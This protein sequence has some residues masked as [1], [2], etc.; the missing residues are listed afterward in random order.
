MTKQN[1]MRGLGEIS[2]EHE[3]PLEK[4]MD[5]YQKFK[6][7]LN[8]REEKYV[9]ENILNNEMYAVDLTERYYRM[10][11]KVIKDEIICKWKEEATK[12]NYHRN[13]RGFKK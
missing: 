11:H 3:I 10:N 9:K 4:V 2:L 1:F 5:I 13:W 7:R 8:M 6:Y 12:I